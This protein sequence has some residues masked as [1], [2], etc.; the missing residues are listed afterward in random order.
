VAD[1]GEVAVDHQLAAA[2][3]I[4]VPDA[5]HVARQLDVI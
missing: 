2:R 4:Q 5:P 3:H 1:E